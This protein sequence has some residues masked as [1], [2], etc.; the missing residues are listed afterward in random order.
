MLGLL[1]GQ[2]ACR[3]AAPA[4]WQAQAMDAAEMVAR[5]EILMFQDCPCVPYMM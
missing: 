2:S 4:A 3:M 5:L 1:G